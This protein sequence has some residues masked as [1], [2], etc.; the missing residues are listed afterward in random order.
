MRCISVEVHG[1]LQ[2]LDDLNYESSL[3]LRSWSQVPLVEAR[4][5]L[6][7][8]LSSGRGVTHLKHQ[9]HEQQYQQ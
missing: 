2:L 4:A 7:D 8:W 1:T 9:P 5:A 6:K 3:A